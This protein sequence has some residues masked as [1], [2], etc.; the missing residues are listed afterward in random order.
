MI[1]PEIVWVANA[2]ALNLLKRGDIMRVCIILNGV[3]VEKE[4]FKV[5][6]LQDHQWNQVVANF[7]LWDDVFFPL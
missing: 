3:E 6:G 1:L 7:T 2:R 4:K 5:Q